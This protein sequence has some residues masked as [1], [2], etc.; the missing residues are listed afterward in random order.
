VRQLN[1]ILSILLLAFQSKAQQINC[2]LK[3]PTVKIHFGEGTV[4]DNNTMVPPRYAR[5]SHYCPSDGYYSYTPYTGHCFRDDWFTVEEDHT[6]GD[7][8]GNMLLVNSSPYSGAFFKTIVTNLKPN[9]MYEFGVWMMNVCKI[10]DKCPF[11]LLPDITIGLQTTSGKN[12]AQLETGEV[13]RRESPEWTQYKFMFTTPPSETSLNLVMIN[14]APGGC[15]NDFALDDITF[16]ECI[17]IPPVKKSTPKSTPLVKTKTPAPK[18]IAK[19][20]A[21]VKKITSAGQPK[22]AV[23]PKTKQAPSRPLQKK[24]NVDI[25]TV[26]P[27]S[28]KPSPS[29]I[30]QKT[31][32][33]PPAPPV[34]RTRTNALVK[35]ILVDAGQIRI[36]LY[37]N[38]EIDDDTVSIY[39]NNKL[40]ASRARLSQKPV[41]F[42]ISVSNANPHHELV[43][44]AEN[45]GSIPPNTSLMIVT[46]GSE[47]QEV[48]I[49]ST[50]QRNAK[51]VVELKE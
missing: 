51:V 4:T 48:F 32:A 11:P 17:I 23:I 41:T 19:K 42:H 12:V 20:P 31:I 7:S 29:A 2:T 9:T 22:T 44:V 39:H 15:G 36:D 6:S 30:K 33:L 10:T 16:R 3:S 18:P 27:D 25:A 21:P 13:V 28:V 47:R 14:H 37:D 38:G 8:K 26:K 46:A 1:L 40:L 34:L 50:K 49:S 35:Q 24:Q 45:L 5:V 43:M